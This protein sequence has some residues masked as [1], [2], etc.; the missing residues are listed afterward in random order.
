MSDID[1]DSVQDRRDTDSN[2]WGKYAGEN[3]LPMWVAD[4]DFRAPQA[5]IDAIKHRAD[6]GIFGYGAA[7]A[8]LKSVIIERLDRLYEWKVDEEDIL[9][10]TGVVPGLNLAC[11][12]LVDSSESV[13]TV[14]PVYH[15]FLSAPGNWGRILHRVRADFVNGKWPFPQQKFEKALTDN[16]DIRLMLLS[17]PFNPIGR[18]LDSSELEKIV[19]SC[20]ENDV[21]ISSDEI[22]CDLLFDNRRHVPTASVS[23]E[24]ADITITFLAPTKTFNLAGLG[25][26]VA[27][28]QNREIRERFE[29][30][31]EG[32]MSSVNIFAYTSML[33]AYRDC[34]TWRLELIKY[35]QA[36]RDYLA[37]RIARMPGISMSPVEATYLAWLDVSK[38][39]LTD[40]MAFFETAGVGLSDG[41]QFD[42]PGFMR[43]NFGCPR[44]T[45][46][47][48]CN[49]IEEAVHSI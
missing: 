41:A 18:L 26:S 23:Q 24:A 8:E 44:D 38:L 47:E 39:E 12:G 25:G 20:Y 7:A 28:I 30:A 9:F 1:F 19:E 11:R 27:I 37:D 49:R 5:I 22:H 34:E 10:L 14:V 42:G 45:L 2:K 16:P 48:A 29:Q 15:P 3:I 35:L 46:V 13:V 40:A 32:A 31:K 43:L 4:M 6:H 36:N 33:T 21:L 17:N